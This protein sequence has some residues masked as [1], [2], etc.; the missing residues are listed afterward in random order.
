MECKQS[1]IGGALRRRFV[2]RFTVN[3]AQIVHL[4]DI[5]NPKGKSL[6]EAKMPLLSDEMGQDGVEV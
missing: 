2:A 3:A 6:L 5:P 4:L 1:E